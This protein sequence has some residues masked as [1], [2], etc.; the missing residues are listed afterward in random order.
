VADA[1]TFAVNGK[2]NGADAV[3][4]A[5]NNAP[6]R[7]DVTT[8]AFRLTGQLAL[9]NLGPG[10]SSLP[11]TVG[12]DTRGTPATAATSACA[13]ASG[14]ARLFGFEDVQAWSSS[15]AALSLVTSP[16]TQGCGALGVRGQGFMSINGAAFT[17]SGLVTNS[18]AS[19]DLFIPTNQPNPSWLGALQM[20]LSCPSGNVFNQYIGQVELTG[21]PTGRYSTLRFPLPAVT[22]STLA[23]ALS[24]C[25]FSFALNVNATGQAWSLDNLRFTP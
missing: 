2:M 14:R 24:D 19:V 11:I 22:R 9:D 10:G 16:V 1:L 13:S 3:F 7:V 20:Y 12:V 8:P 6:M 17:T 4:F 15:Q 5:S 21:K 23:Q 25:S 18:A